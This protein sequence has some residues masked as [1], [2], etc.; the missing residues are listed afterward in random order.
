MSKDE[1]LSHFCKTPS[2]WGEHQNTPCSGFAKGPRFLNM[3]MTFVLTPLSHYSSII[4]PRIQFLLSLLE[5]LTIDFPSHFITSIIDVY[6]DMETRDKLIFP[7]TIT[8]ILR[9]FSILILDSPYFT[10]MGAISIGSIQHNEAQLSTEAAMD[11][12]NQS[13]RS[14]SSFFFNSFHLCSFLFSSWCNLRGHHGMR[15]AR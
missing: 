12:D 8:R 6:Q 4:E 13:C 7:S 1:L 15:C 10:T 5:D 14:C 2:I 3:V 11:K 9:H